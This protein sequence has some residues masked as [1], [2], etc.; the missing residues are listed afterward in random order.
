MKHSVLTLALAAIFA[1]VIS[2]EASAQTVPAAENP[3][4]ELSAPSVVKR[5][6][7]VLRVDGRKLTEAQ[8]L[9]YITDRCGKAYSSSWNSGAKTYGA[10]VGLLISSA[11]TIPAGMTGMVVGTAKI[12]GGALGV[13]LGAAISGSLGEEKDI[14][15]DER[16]TINKGAAWFIG[17]TIISAIGFSTLIAGAVCVPVG[18]SKMN[19]VANRCNT[20]NQGGEMTMV[21]GPAPHGLGLTLNF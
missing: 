18:K 6:G 3:S 7:K 11:V 2:S 13:S 10:G 14:T 12:I 5:S 15:P 17:G 20:A 9:D 8:T 1:G 16:D 19:R 21:L 4:S